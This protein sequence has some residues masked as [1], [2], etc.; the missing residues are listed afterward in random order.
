M[1]ETTEIVQAQSISATADTE[2]P[3]GVVDAVLQAT[4]VEANV[5]SADDKL[6][7]VEASEKSVDSS[8]TESDEAST[9][10]VPAEET[11]VDVAPPA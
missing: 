7:L 9:A 2:V 4:T 1:T 6:E 11:L 8:E 10:H 3:S 5:A